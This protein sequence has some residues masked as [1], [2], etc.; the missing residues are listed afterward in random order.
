MDGSGNQAVLAIDFG[1]SSCVV[2]ARQG[3]RRPPWRL[4]GSMRTPSVLFA[5]DDGVLLVGHLADDCHRPPGAALRSPKARL[6]QD[7]PVVLGGRAHASG[8]LVATVLRWLYTEAT[9]V[10]GEPTGV[11]LTHPATWTSARLDALRL[12]G[13]RWPAR[14]RLQPEPV[15]AAAAL[16]D[17]LDVPAGAHVAVYDLGAGTFDVAVLHRTADGFE[18]VGEPDGDPRIGGDL[19]DELIEAAVGPRLGDDVWRA[20]VEADDGWDE[21]GAQLRRSVRRAKELVSAHDYADV[22]LTLPNGM[23]PATVRLRREEVAALLAPP[24][25]ETVDRLAAAVAAAGLHPSQLHAVHL[26][27]GASAMPVVIDAVRERFP[28]VACIRRADPKSVVALGRCTPPSTPRRPRPATTMPPAAPAGRGGAGS[29]WASPQRRRPPH[30]PPGRWR[31]RPGADRWA[32]RPANRL[33]APPPMRRRTAGPVRAVRSA[34][35]ARRVRV[36]RRARRARA[37]PRPRPR[38]WPPAPPHRG[39][40]RHDGRRRRGGGAGRGP[41]GR[42][43]VRRPIAGRQHHRRDIVG[44]ATSPTSGTGA[45]SAPADATPATAA[46]TAGTTP[47]AAAPTP[48]AASLDHRPRTTATTATPTTAAPTTAPD[49]EHPPPQ[50]PRRCGHRALLVGADHRW[51]HEDGDCSQIRTCRLRVTLAVGTPA[52]NGG[53]AITAYRVTG[54]IFSNGVVQ[55]GTIEQV[56]PAAGSIALVV[57][58]LDLPSSYIRWQV[59]AVNQ[60]GTGPAVTARATVPALVGTGDGRSFELARVAGLPAA[61]LPPQPGCGPEYTVCAPV[62]ACRYG[63][64]RWTVLGPSSRADPAPLA[65]VRPRPPVARRPPARRAVGPCHRGGPPR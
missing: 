48:T 35:R 63:G 15:A 19:F 49:H 27:G 34:R 45:T 53:A 54:T 11:V 9:G 26:V 4:A 25:L 33:P 60:A 65:P 5:D 59:A 12:A 22:H 21:A 16:I 10:V 18:L 41:G 51:L 17:E 57:G 39:R 40:G 28:G 56:V 31:G 14:L 20:I 50:P 38:R 42:A 37:A 1:T 24:V 46:S 29:C 8:E 64:G 44:C 61:G 30:W 7:A 6:G 13:E 3:G 62:H 55:P 2:A 47:T 58:E 43:H 36:V 23:A 32:R 52:D